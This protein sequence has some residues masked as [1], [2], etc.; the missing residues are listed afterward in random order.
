M[1]FPSGD[2]EITLIFDYLE[3][4]PSQSQCEALRSKLAGVKGALSVQLHTDWMRRQQLTVVY[5]RDIAPDAMLRKMAE[6]LRE[7]PGTGSP[8]N[9]ACSVSDADS[10]VA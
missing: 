1:Q 10:P 5:Q 8:D 3:F 6:A 9:N 4:C 7:L 2:A